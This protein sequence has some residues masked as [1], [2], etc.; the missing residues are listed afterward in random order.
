MASGLGIHGEK[1][2]NH[3]NQI[4]PAPRCSHARSQKQPLRDLAVIDPVRIIPTGTSIVH[5]IA[6]QGAKLSEVATFATSSSWDEGRL[7]EGAAKRNSHALSRAGPNRKRARRSV[8]AMRDELGQRLDKLSSGA[9]T[10]ARSARRKRARLQPA[11]PRSEARDSPAGKPGESV[12]VC[13]SVTPEAAVR[14]RESGQV[15]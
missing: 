6:G 8:T 2:G 14:S 9:G 12:E 10:V 4:R 7:R 11:L 15:Y 13:M 3:S 1:R 5:S